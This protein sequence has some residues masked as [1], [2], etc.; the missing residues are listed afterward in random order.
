MLKRKFD[1]RQMVLALQKELNDIIKT[2]MK[3]ISLFLSGTINHR[4]ANCT[5]LNNG[6]LIPAFS[7]IIR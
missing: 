5:M 4:S 7:G 2:G 1:A 3:N 6:T